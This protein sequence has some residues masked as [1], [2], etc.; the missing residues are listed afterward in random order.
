MNNRRTVLRDAGFDP[1]TAVSVKRA[2]VARREAASSRSPSAVLLL[3][4]LAC[5]GTTRMSG[6]GA[7][8]TTGAAASAVDIDTGSFTV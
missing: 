1:T 4:A 6:V 3:L 2:H 5:H 7:D 8:T